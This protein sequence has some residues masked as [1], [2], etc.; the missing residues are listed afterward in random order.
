MGT[1]DLS[2]TVLSALV[3]EGY[4]VCLCVTQPDKPVGR[5]HVI[6][7]PPVKIY[8]RE[9]SLEVY[10]PDSL[11]TSEALEKIQSVN[12]DLIVTAAY[13][14]ILPQAML[15]VPVYGAIN[16]HASLLPSYRGAAPVQYSI[17]NGDDVTGVTV[18][19]MDKG[20]DTGDILTKCAVKIDISDTTE[21]LMKKLAEEGSKLLLNTIGGYIDGSITPVP[22]D[23]SKATMSPPIKPEDALIDWNSS[24]RSIH[25]KIRA[26]T[27]WPCAYTFSGGNKMKIYVSRIA[28][29][30]TPEEEAF[31]PGTVI[32]A[33]KSDLLIK[34]GEGALYL[35]EL[36]GPSGKRLKAADVAHNFR[37]GLTLG[38]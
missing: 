20:M 30:I 23:S 8:A 4:N 1:P 7:S 35:L 13:G 12:P 11:K 19:K 18:M 21:T 28:D 15:D 3:A 32:R 31:A 29:E 16:V 24:A 10:Q 38:D 5:K 22:Q 37:V 6:T 9:H 17:M 36:Q 2:V 25:D 27:E 26:L 33:H 14:K 34:C